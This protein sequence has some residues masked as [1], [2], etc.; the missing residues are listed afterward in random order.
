[1]RIAHLS[2]ATTAL[3]TLATAAHADN[4][5]MYA[6]A[7][8]TADNGAIVRDMGHALNVTSTRQLFQCP[9]DKNDRRIVN[10]KLYVMDNNRAPRE[11]VE[12]YLYNLRASS[13][14]RL[15]AE[16]SPATLAQDADGDHIG[17]QV[18]TFNPADIP[19]EF[20]PGAY[21][22][23]CVVPKV[24]SDGAHSGLVGYRIV[25]AN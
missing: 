1:M 7:Q 9:V 2:L 10:A 3:L 21:H 19:T 14:N 20:D 25:E 23:V 15:D 17:Y 12:C 18:W 5:T 16:F 22:L 8:C 11:D 6:G 13:G 4:A 24:A